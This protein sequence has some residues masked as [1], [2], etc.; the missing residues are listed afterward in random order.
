MF[1][2]LSANSG[3]GGILPRTGSYSNKH[4]APYFLVIFHWLKKEFTQELA[5]KAEKRIIQLRVL[6]CFYTSLIEDQPQP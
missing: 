3:D 4:N 6:L 5:E 2:S 1:V